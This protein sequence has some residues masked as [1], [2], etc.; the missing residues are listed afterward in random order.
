VGYALGIGMGIMDQ[1][2]VVAPGVED[3]AVPPPWLT[4]PDWS[5]GPRGWPA[6]P[7]SPTG[8]VSARTPRKLASAF[9]VILGAAMA[10]VV[11]A[12]LVAAG[13]LATSAWSARRQARDADRATAATRAQVQSLDHQIDQIDAELARVSAHSRGAET[14][15]ESAN[16]SLAAL[17]FELAATQAHQFDQGVSIGAVQS[18][19]GGVQAALNDIAL[20]FPGQATAALHK[21]AG[22]CATAG[23]TEG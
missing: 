6:E 10:A 4:E 19:L 9:R 1:S 23:A 22:S 3:P 11:I 15:L 20:G 18:C 5:T 13:L 21:V 17:R 2:R 14:A 16:R 12:V 8:P 7:I